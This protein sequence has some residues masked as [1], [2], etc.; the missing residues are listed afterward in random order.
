M[1]QQVKN[2]VSDFQMSGNEIQPGKSEF[3]RNFRGIAQRGHL[4]IC[5]LMVIDRF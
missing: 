5:G 2:L 4:N 1:P 3:F